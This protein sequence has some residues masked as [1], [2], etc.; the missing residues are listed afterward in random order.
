MKGLHIAKLKVFL[1]YVSLLAS[2]MSFAQSDR[3]LF[4]SRVYH[5]P[6]SPY[7]VSAQRVQLR[8]SLITKGAEFIDIFLPDGSSITASLYEHERRGKGNFT[9]RG[10]SDSASGIVG[11]TGVTLSWSGDG[12]LFDNATLVDEESGESISILPGETY[13]FTIND[14]V[15]QFTLQVE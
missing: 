3:Q 2:S 12:A 6:Q 14:G 4:Q 5:S 10:S 11:V 9:W 13:T 1:L 15:H 7:G 8:H